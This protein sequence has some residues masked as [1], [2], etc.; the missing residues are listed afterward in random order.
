MKILVGGDFSPCYRLDTLIRERLFEDIF[1]GVIDVFRGNDFNIINFET[2]VAKP[3]FKSI[4]KIGA[5][6]KTTPEACEALKYL[7]VDIVTLANNHAFDY[8]LP[9]LQLTL[10]HLEKQGIKSVGVGLTLEEAREPLYVKKR[11]ETLAIVNCCEHEY[12]IA[13]RNQA[14]TNP[15]DLI[16]QYKAITEAKKKADYVLVI[17]H[18]GSEQYQLPSPRM[19]DT[20]RYFI[21][22]GAD[23]VVNHHQHCYS[24]MEVY[25]GKPIYYGLGNF[26]FDALLRPWPNGWC[27]GMLVQLEFTPE[28]VK[29]KTFSYEQFRDTPSVDLLKDRSAFDEKF[30]SLCDVIVN[31]DMLEEEAEKY[32]KQSERYLLTKFQPWP[33]RYLKGAFYR[34]W[35]PS[36]V[37][38][39]DLAWIQ[40]IVLCQSH[41]DKFEY[42]LNHNARGIY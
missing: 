2:T 1:K 17:V 6:L 9:G 27:E 31:R 41:R 38:Q 8:G 36:L 26:A 22:V 19:Q 33:G 42:F 13:T 32:F 37:S 7:G 16:S 29:H 11:N 23:A 14:G 39:Q 10:E 3:E 25:C 12:G 4:D 20:Y 18:G 15:L 35:L 21:E 24:G 28:G 34:G 5:R 30:K 40:N